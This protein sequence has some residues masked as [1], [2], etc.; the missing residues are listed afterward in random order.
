MPVC[1]VSYSNKKL[2]RKYVVYKNEYYS[3]VT[4]FC[5]IKAMWELCKDFQILSSYTDHKLWG[6]NRSFVI[7]VFLYRNSPLN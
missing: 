2:T 5:Q 6:K 3:V 1:S 7:R 4:Q